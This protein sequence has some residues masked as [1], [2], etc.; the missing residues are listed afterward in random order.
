MERL[1]PPKP[2]T[3]EA[4][5]ITRIRLLRA[6]HGTEPS[7]GTGGTA[8]QTSGEFSLNW[9]RLPDA[10]ADRLEDFFEAHDGYKA[11]EYALPLEPKARVFLCR[12]WTRRRTKPGYAL[13]RATFE[14]VIDP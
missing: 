14:E 10:D 8:R 13:I 6:L 5:R 11:F 7:A 3:F 4:D 1:C 2:P 12:E 9:S